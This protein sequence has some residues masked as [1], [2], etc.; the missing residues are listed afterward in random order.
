MFFEVKVEGKTYKFNDADVSIE[1]VKCVYDKFYDHV[2][3]QTPIFFGFGWVLSYLSKHGRNQTLNLNASSNNAIE[4]HGLSETP[5]AVQQPEEMQPFDD[6]PCL[7]YQPIE[8]QKF[9]PAN[10]IIEE[11]IIMITFFNNTTNAHKTIY[12]ETKDIPLISK[13]KK[14]GLQEISN[15][16]VYVFPQTSITRHLLDFHQIEASL[17]N[18]HEFA[19]KVYDVHAVL[20]KPPCKKILIKSVMEFLF[21]NYSFDI[22]SSVAYDSLY[23]DFTEF[24]YKFVQ[25]ISLN[26]IVGNKLFEDILKYLCL[27]SADGHV[28]FLKLKSQPTMINFDISNKLHNLYQSSYVRV[29]SHDLRPLP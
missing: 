22:L 6:K 25:R 12:C 1:D 3:V 13:V 16:N 9:T 28:K 23:R 17:T 7:L 14:Y 29:L 20:H 26:V 24:N 4:T 21:S 10:N 11:G 18:T 8:F 2:K 27:A 15:I 19:Q 5:S